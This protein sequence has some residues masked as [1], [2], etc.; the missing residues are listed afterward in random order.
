MDEKEVF[1]MV[2]SG[3]MT[4]EEFEAWIEAERDKAFE[5]GYDYGQLVKF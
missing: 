5:F 1:E 3:K 2:A 4:W